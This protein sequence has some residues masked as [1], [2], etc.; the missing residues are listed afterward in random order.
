LRG[1]LSRRG[2][3]HG[4]ADSPV[5][6]CRHPLRGFLSRRGMHHGF[7]DSPVAKPSPASRVHGAIRTSPTGSLHPRVRG[8]HP[9]L[10]A[11][12]RFAGLV[13]VVALLLAGVVSVH[14]RH[15]R[16]LLNERRDPW[17]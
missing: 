12:T 8:T 14:R 3:D 16:P 13:I 4:F 1:F 15:H 17:I 6:I 2:L 11:V 5:A 7:A 10:Y 9:W